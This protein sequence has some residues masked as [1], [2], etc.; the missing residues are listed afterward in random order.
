MPTLK[1]G[2]MLYVI[3]NR[4]TKCMLHM[5]KL[6]LQHLV[7]VRFHFRKTLQM[8]PPPIFSSAF[9]FR[10]DPIPGPSWCEI[11]NNTQYQDQAGMNLLNIP[12]TRTQLV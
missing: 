10:K 4:I 1:F 9:Y 2:Q 7:D 8:H 3:K 12:N 6:S 5:P 11:L